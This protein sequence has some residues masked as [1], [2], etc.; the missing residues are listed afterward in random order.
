MQF[1]RTPCPLLN[2]IAIVACDRDSH[3]IPHYTL[4]SMKQSR[5]TYRLDHCNAPYVGKIQPLTL[6]YVPQTHAR[7]YV[8]LVQPHFTPRLRGAQRAFVCS[9]YVAQVLHDNDI[10]VYNFRDRQPQPQS[11]AQRQ[12]SALSVSVWLVPDFARGLTR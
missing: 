4:E 1:E 12:S 5:E 11:P 3:N 7:Q 2:A 8:H 10:C 6:L 9:S